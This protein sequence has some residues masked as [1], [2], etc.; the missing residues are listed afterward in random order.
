MKAFGFNRIHCAKQALYIGFQKQN[1]I[2]P[3]D[4]EVLAELFAFSATLTP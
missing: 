4:E 3:D 1:P 2:H